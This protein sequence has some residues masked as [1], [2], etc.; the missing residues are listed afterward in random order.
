MN[1]KQNNKKARDW[2]KDER[3][4]CNKSGATPLHYKGRELLISKNIK[5]SW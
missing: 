4:A 3:T 1:Y 5:L 2:H